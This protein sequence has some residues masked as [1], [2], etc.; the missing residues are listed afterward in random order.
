[1]ICDIVYTGLHGAFWQT[2]TSE[3]KSLLAN[4]RF[5]LT[6]GYENPCPNINETSLCGQ[7]VLKPRHQH[8]FPKICWLWKSDGPA[9]D[10]IWISQRRNFVIVRGYVYGK[11]LPNQAK[12]IGS[13]DCKVLFD[14][15]GNGNSDQ[16]K[17]VFQ[18]S[19][20]VIIKFTPITYAFCVLL[21]LTI[22][23]ECIYDGQSVWSRIT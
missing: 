9:I 21:L 22:K 11:Q 13:V 12:S 10:V 8:F 16:L 2:R 14:S 5:Q 7:K 1:M 4:G 23:L 6:S 3:L 19:M 20:I 15:G 17:Y 18:Y